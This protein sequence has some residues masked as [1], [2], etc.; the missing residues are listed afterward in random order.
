MYFE[1][2]REGM[3]HFSTDFTHLREVLESHFRSQQRAVEI[4]QEPDQDGQIVTHREESF[5]KLQKEI[6]GICSSL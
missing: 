5:V 1:V 4:V 3:L 2:E 6:D